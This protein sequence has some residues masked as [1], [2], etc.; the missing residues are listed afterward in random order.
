M[1][2]ICSLVSFLALALTT[3]T[4]NF[5]LI[6][7]YSG[8]TFFDKWDFAADLGQYYDNTTSGDVFWLGKAN[9]SSLAYVDSTTG[10]AIIRIDNTTFVPYNDKR[11]SVRIYHLYTVTTKVALSIEHHRYESRPRTTSTTVPSGFLMHTTSPG[12]VE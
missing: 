8:S 2:G 6:Q 7:E 9:S 3:V 12:A 10:H 1:R 4:A 11:N 5:T